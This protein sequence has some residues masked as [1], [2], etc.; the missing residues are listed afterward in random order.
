MHFIKNMAKP[1]KLYKLEMMGLSVQRFCFIASDYLCWKI[2][3]I[4][5]AC[6]LFP[7][8]H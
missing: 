6:I 2:P 3:K 5:V 1:K 4:S 7:I 8:I